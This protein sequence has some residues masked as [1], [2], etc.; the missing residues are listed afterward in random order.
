MDPSS[1][2]N[3]LSLSSLYQNKDHKLIHDRP[4]PQLH[5]LL[6]HF[7]TTVM[8]LYCFLELAPLAVSFV[9]LLLLIVFTIQVSFAFLFL[10]SQIMSKHQALDA[11]TL[12]LVDFRLS[13]CS[14]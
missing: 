3:A 8:H 1:I 6:S 7:I 4:C 5:L 14:K 2:P 13:F 10:L 9:S 11:N 12:L